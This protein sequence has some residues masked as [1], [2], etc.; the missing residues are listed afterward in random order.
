MR[1]WNSVEGCRFGI[2]TSTLSKR[3]RKRVNSQYIIQDHIQISAFDCT[4]THIEC[5]I[6]WWPPER[7]RRTWKLHGWHHHIRLTTDSSLFRTIVVSTNAFNKSPAYVSE[8]LGVRRNQSASQ[9]VLRIFNRLITYCI[10]LCYQLR[11]SSVSPNLSFR[12]LCTQFPYWSSCASFKTSRHN[13]HPPALSS[14]SSHKFVRR[15]DQPSLC[16]HSA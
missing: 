10:W 7:P 4:Y 6:Q 12:F 5:G 16:K 1:L 13:S 8:G 11:Y 15:T 2:Y 3:S 14:R 9:I